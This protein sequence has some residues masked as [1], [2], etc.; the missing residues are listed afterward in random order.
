MSW[1]C[2]F[3]LYFINKEFERLHYLHIKLFLEASF[4]FLNQCASMGGF[5]SSFSMEC[6][7]HFSDHCIK[8]VFR[9]IYLRQSKKVLFSYPLFCFHFDL[10]TEHAQK[11]IITQWPWIYFSWY[12]VHVCFIGH[13]SNRY[14]FLSNIW[15]TCIIP[16]KT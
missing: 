11:S 1:K 12:M 2:S 6:N 13:T 10:G 4:F 15:A 8:S 9:G 5:N 3:N 14:Y 7:Q 16:H